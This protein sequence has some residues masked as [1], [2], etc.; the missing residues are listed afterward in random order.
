[1]S[2]SGRN[3]RGFLW[4]TAHNAESRPEK[5]VPKGKGLTAPDP[6]HVPCPDPDHVPCPDLPR[7]KPRAVTC[8]QITALVRQRNLSPPKTESLSV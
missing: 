6:D 2:A 8:T 4:K 1:M 5:A 3:P 7:E